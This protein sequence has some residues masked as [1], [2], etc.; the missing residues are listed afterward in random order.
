M[1]DSI[2]K[3][4][5]QADEI[6]GAT[7]LVEFRRSRI[8]GTGGY[9]RKDIAAESNV[10]EYVGEKISKAESTQRCEAG[11][12]YIFT[13]DETYDL[14][15]SVDWNP[16]RLINHSCEPNCDALIDDEHRV[17]IVASRNIKAGEELTFNYNYDLEDYR[18]HPCQCGA[19]KCVGFIVAEEFFDHVRNAA[20][21][22]KS[23]APSAT[24]GNSPA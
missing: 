19:T 15:G 22:L 23:C 12:A 11:N 3:Q 10:I 7:E 2:A 21:L 18:E 13:G 9:A 8:H 6:I 16:A 17:W 4:D 24:R 5:S 1:D 20:E 14:D